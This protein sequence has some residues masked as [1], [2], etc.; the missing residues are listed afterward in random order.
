MQAADIDDKKNIP[1]HK[2]EFSEFM[3]NWGR[4]NREKKRGHT[5]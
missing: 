5:L 3:Q 2:H 1:T 4:V